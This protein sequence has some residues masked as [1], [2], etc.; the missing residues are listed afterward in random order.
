[1]ARKQITIFSRTAPKSGIDCFMCKRSDFA[2][3]ALTCREGLKVGS[4][5][6][7]P[8]FWDLRTHFPMDA[9]NNGI[10]K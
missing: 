3:K 8:R 10:A 7:C 2:G 5:K 4:A 9:N 1:M 6:T